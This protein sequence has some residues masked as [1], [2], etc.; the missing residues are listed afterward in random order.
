MVS[1]RVRSAMRWNFSSRHLL[2]SSSSYVHAIACTVK[3]IEGSA[4]VFLAPARFD[5]FPFPLRG[6]SP[7]SLL[8]TEYPR[9]PLTRTLLSRTEHTSRPIL[10][11]L[12]REVRA[13]RVGVEELEDT[14][15][16]LWRQLEVSGIGL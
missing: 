11:P 2:S 13:R 9:M 10:D 12:P 8:P 6:I 14:G 4:S 1:L 7:R 15:I 3:A 5:P 16:G